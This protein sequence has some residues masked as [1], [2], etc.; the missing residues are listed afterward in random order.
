MSFNV[1]EYYDWSAL[2]DQSS[3]ER[4]MLEINTGIEA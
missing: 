4:M 1:H 3:R 2:I